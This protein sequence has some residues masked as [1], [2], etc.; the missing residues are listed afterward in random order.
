M[1]DGKDRLGIEKRHCRQLVGCKRPSGHRQDI[2]QP[3]EAFEC[4]W[5]QFGI[6]LRRIDVNLRLVEF[7]LQDVIVAQSDLQVA[8][9]LLPPGGIFT[10]DARIFTAARSAGHSRRHDERQRPEDYLC[11]RAGWRLRGGDGSPWGFGCQNG[12]GG[13]GIWAGVQVARTT[14]LVGRLAPWQSGHRQKAR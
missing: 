9:S 7:P 11:L 6:R 1:L 4:R 5:Y 13:A 12:C 10:L 8:G 3:V 14:V 2:I